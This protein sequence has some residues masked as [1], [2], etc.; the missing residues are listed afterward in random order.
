MKSSQIPQYI[1]NSELY[2]LMYAGHVIFEHD[3][4][5]Y[6]VTESL[7][8]IG[9][10]IDIPIITEEFCKPDFQINNI[11]DLEYLL[12]TIKYWDIPVPI[13]VYR[14]I[15]SNPDL[16]YSRFIYDDRHFVDVKHFEDKVF[17]MKLNMVKKSDLNNLQ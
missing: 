6:T 14:F 13:E 3:P 9:D 5:Q 12:K 8:E 16:D 11:E 2:K 10:D 17:N 15:I 7:I 1:K 4:T